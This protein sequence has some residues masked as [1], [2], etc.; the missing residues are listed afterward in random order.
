MNFF[1]KYL[2]HRTAT[3]YQEGR[4]LQRRFLLGVLTPPFVVLLI[5]GSVIYWQLDRYIKSQ[6]IE[7][8]HRSASTTAVKLDREFS[9]RQTILQR[10]GEDLFV[11]KNG[12]NN[13]LTNLQLNRD[14]CK[15]HISVKRTFIGVENNA[16]DPFLPEFA[17]YNFSA[18]AVDIGY[19]RVSDELK[20]KQDQS[21]NDRLSAYK[22]FFPETIAL[23][24]VDED[25][26]IISS[27]QS[28][29]SEKVIEL[30]KENI[31]QS[32]DQNIIGK[33]TELDKVKVAIFAYPIKSGSVLVAYDL[34]NENFLHETW[35]STPIDKSNSL[36]FMTDSE[37]NPTYPEV[38]FANNI[39]ESINS[40]KNNK[41]ATVKLNNIEHIAVGSVA[42]ESNWVSI[43][44]S[45]SAAVLSP[46]RDAQ[47]IAV[48]I[49]G[50]LIVGF[51]WVGAYFI[52]KT[53]KSI[54][55]LVSGALVF[56][57]GKLDYKIKLN[58]ADI[59][60]ISLA[61]TMNN[62]AERIATAEAELDA[63]NKEFISVATHELRTPLTAIIG[64]LSMVYEDMGSKLSSDVKP[65]IEQAYKG[66]IKL[67]DLVNDLLDV[68][69]LEGGRTEFNLKP[70]NISPII[71][72]VIDN[73]SVTAKEKQ[74]SLE[75]KSS[76]GATAHADESRLG[77]VLNNF[78]SN[79]IKYNR[80]S[81][82]ITVS[83][84]QKDGYLVVS[85]QDT[86]LGIPKEQQA[87]MFE[88][89]FRVQDA[90]R[91][92]VVGTG[93]GMYITKKYIE[94]MGGKVWFES[95]HG[96]GTTFYFTIPLAE[97]KSRTV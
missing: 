63:K 52:Q 76:D 35:Q 6:A 56:S 18:R 38:Q 8:L 28:E 24:I 4:N 25:G 59:E 2:N 30:L 13:S 61:N 39:K 23:L 51:L 5:L 64:Y 66:T 90:D 11:I 26:Q 82:T 81:G 43:T 88:K 32:L 60:F 20:T 21:I 57:S 91:K 68:A 45:P 62:M 9:L 7:D 47:L 34:N 27:A 79:A 83:H 44:A 14:T 72:S 3:K 36:A 46:M 29:S 67:K 85:V 97:G 49:I 16:C 17:K 50:S 33:V 42:G 94:A 92:N 37:G 19:D 55:R 70:V 84:Q 74:V 78:V 93:L 48:I 31:N 69:R 22:Q 73:L 53:L 86:G 58:D 65:A 54:I 40:I 89:F 10:T 75:Y 15:Q 71:N 87:H 80:P 96:K 12:Y 41:Y 1:K 95:V 77:I